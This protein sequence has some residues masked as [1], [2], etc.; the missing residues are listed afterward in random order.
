MWLVPNR[1]LGSGF[2]RSATEIFRQTPGFC[3]VQSANAA[4]P[5]TGC[6]VCPARGSAPAAMVRAIS[7]IFIDTHLHAGSG[8]KAVWKQCVK[9]HH[10]Y[11]APIF[12]RLDQT[13]RPPKRFPHP[14]ASQSARA[15]LTPPNRDWFMSLLITPRIIPSADGNFCTEPAPCFEHGKA[16]RRRDHKILRCTI[17]LRPRTCLYC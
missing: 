3:C 1:V 10:I 2:G 12:H 7:V 13:S 9:L 6:A 8:D 11:S 4:C 16:G 14:S 17:P 5:V 15:S